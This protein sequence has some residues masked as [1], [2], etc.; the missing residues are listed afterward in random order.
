MD[1]KETILRKIKSTRGA[2]GSFIKIYNSVCPICKM[3]IT[4]SNGSLPFNQYC[5]KCKDKVRPI[6]EKLKEKMEK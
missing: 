1:K 4:K 3:K 5:H 6:L 2:V